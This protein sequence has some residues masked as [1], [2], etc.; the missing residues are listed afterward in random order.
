MKSISLALVT[1]F[2]TFASFAQET[3]K[4][5]TISG[6]VKD[7]ISKTPI[8]YANIVLMKDSKT[9]AG[10][11]TNDQGRFTLVNIGSGNYTLLLSFVGYMAKQ[12]PLFVGSLSDFLDLSVIELEED[13]NVLNEVEI[14]SKQEDISAK[15]DK[16]TFS[17]ADNISQTG[18]SVLQA[19]QNLPGVTIQD[20]KLQLRGNDKVMVLIDG[21]QTG[22]TG[23]GNQSGLDNIPSSAIDKIEIINNPSAKFDAN[24]NAGI[25]NIIYKKNKQEGLNGKVGISSGFGALWERKSN[26]PTI[27]PQYSM[28]PKINPS[29]SLNYSK[30]KI[31]AFF[32]GDYLYT[33]T[34]NKNEFVTRTYDDETI[35]NQQ[36]KRNRNTHFTTI[37]SGLDWKYNDDNMFTFSG[38]F[39]IEKIIDH[40]DEPFFNG[41]FSE[42]LRLWQFLEDE[43][44]TTAMATAS[45]QHTFREAGHVLNAGINYT[46]HRENEK[47]FFDNILPDSSGKDSFKLISDE[48]VLDI[49]VDYIEPLK[50]GRFETGLKFRN[51]QIPTNMQFFPGADSPIDVDAGGVATYKELIP[52][53]YGNYIFEN[54]KIEAEVGMR[55]EYVDL[56]Y[57]V[58]PNHPTYKSD[59]YDYTQPFP[60]IRF[61][62]KFN[63]K[64]KLTAFFSRRVDRPSEV[65]IRIFPKYDDAE[66]IKVGNPALRPQFSSAFELGYKTSFKNGYFFASAYHRFVNGTITRIATTI[67]GSNLIYN[68]FQNA[69]RSSTTGLELVYSKRLAAWYA[70]NLNG[71]GYQND[72]EAFT[73]TN[74][75]PVPS[76]F[77]GERQKLFSGNVKWNNTFNFTKA[78]S[79]QLSAVYLAPDIIPQGKIDSRFSVDLGLKRMVQKGKGE[80]FINA[81]DVF[82]TLTVRKEIQGNGF[83]YNSKDYYETQVIRFGYSYKF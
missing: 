56:K 57:E 62:Y 60:N 53:V 8:S 43:L 25:I 3:P 34:L 11:V 32:Q 46:Y 70:F 37:K 63:D 58:D 30:G 7:K 28:T 52:A 59:G 19:M 45:Y 69:D 71:N 42:R 15:M 50:H 29:L 65:D 83:R 6:T 64:N 40:G 21:K 17:L 27:R 23:F 5:V 39:G 14:T 76:V 55:F 61:A 22:I 13:T 41:D 18:G 10:T 49:N 33:E 24:G 48:K 4:K 74:L 44:K 68:V 80:I 81:T 78:L 72:I 79:G 75:Y 67:P 36:T 38:L 77:H 82:N 2:F 47:Y 20:G 51:R 9:V 16:K 31:N 26:L 1:F 66:I 12:Q 35:V 73:V 54:N